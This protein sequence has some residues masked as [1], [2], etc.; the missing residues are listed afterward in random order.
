[1]NPVVLEPTGLWA[2]VGAGAMGSVGSPSECLACGGSTP[3]SSGGGGFLSRGF[4]FGGISRATLAQS[5]LR[6]D[7]LLLTKLITIAD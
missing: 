1:M 2:R 3:S 7:W 4:F 6:L 5:L